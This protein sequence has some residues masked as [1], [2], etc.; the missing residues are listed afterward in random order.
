MSDATAT[1]TPAA[2]APKAPEAPKEPPFTVDVLTSCTT[3][4][5]R[6]AW[7]LFLSYRADLEKIRTA[8]IRATLEARTLNGAEALHRQLLEAGV[9]EISRKD[10]VVS[11]TTTFEIIQLVIKNPETAHFDAIAI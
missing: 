6:K 3:R 1:P 2:E 10:K 9:K 8:P 4:Y 5:T 7:N 11:L